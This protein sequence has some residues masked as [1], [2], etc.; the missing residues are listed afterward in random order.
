MRIL[1]YHQDLLKKQNKATH[2]KRFVEKAFRP[3][4][5]SVA[6]RIHDCGLIFRHF[7]QKNSKNTPT[8]EKQE[9]TMSNSEPFPSKGTEK[10]IVD[11]D[12][13]TSVSDFGS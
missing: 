13:T 10:L 7:I 2:V 6:E 4:R 12:G 8:L 11:L 1:K 9:S 3:L 5:V